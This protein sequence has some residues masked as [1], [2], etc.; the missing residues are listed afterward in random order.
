MLKDS[1]VYTVKE[2]GEGDGRGWVGV[3]N[4]TTFIGYLID[5]I[6]RFSLL[7]RDTNLLVM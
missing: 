3:I 2:E 1:I 7:Y 5:F 6:K 4:Q